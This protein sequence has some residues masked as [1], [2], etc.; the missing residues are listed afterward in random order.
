MTNILI[1]DTK[2]KRPKEEK[3][4]ETQAKIGVM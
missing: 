1:G 2:R 4:Y 3:A